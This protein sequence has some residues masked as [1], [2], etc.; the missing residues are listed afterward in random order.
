MLR[1]GVTGPMASGKS[2]VARRF[3]ER[4]AALIE[5]DALGWEVLREPEVRE[6]VAALFGRS[7]LGADGSVDR[8]ALGRIVFGDASELNRLNA[9]VQPRLLR[10]VRDALDS[11]RGE[12]VL[13]LDAALLGAWNLAPELDGVVDVAAP[14][15][16]RIARLAAFKGFPEAEARER[17]EGQRLPPLRGARRLWR[18]EN[19]GTRTQLLKRADEVW[20]E[21]ERLRS[22]A[23]SG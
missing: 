1:I 9:L 6:R 23:R 16:T 14:A 11:A 3:E 21:I 5:G 7:V 19:A 4:G 17:V 20:G 12:G 8:R 13:V 15:E 10:R 18:I 22:E 2:D